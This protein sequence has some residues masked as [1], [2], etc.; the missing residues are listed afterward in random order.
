MAVPAGAGGAG[1]RA[2]SGAEARSRAA[3]SRA[4][5]VSGPSSSPVVHAGR[6]AARS[7]R[8]HGLEHVGGLERP[9]DQGKDAEP[10]EGEGLF[11]P[12]VETG[13]LRT[14]SLSSRAPGAA[15]STRLDG[16]LDAAGRWIGAL[17]TLAP[18]RLLHPRQVRDHVLPFV[19]LAPL[20]ESTWALEDRSGCRSGAPWLRQSPHERAGRQIETAVLQ[21][22]WRKD[23]I[24]TLFSVSVWTNPRKTLS[25]WSVTPS[26]TH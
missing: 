22:S 21:A 6:S 26:A 12:L 13:L 17:Q 8:V 9:A 1:S 14:G 3:R 10:M 2:T 25:P 18:A 20:D 5:C 11:E 7:G 23:R 15:S 24:T 19:P 16:F 4:I